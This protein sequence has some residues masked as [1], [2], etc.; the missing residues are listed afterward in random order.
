MAR[1]ELNEDCMKVSLLID[2]K[3]KL[4]A[5]T[6]CVYKLVYNIGSKKVF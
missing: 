5:M 4:E 3:N 6:K 2:H 1:Q